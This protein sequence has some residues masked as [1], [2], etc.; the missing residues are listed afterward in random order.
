MLLIHDPNEEL[1]SSG[2]LQ[3]TM[4]RTQNKLSEGLSSQFVSLAPVPI[5]VFRS[6]PIIRVLSLGIALII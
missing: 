4:S 6:T 3:I 1:T 2:P 5:D